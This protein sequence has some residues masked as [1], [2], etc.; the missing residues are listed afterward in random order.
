MRVAIALVLMFASFGSAQA[1][2]L[3]HGRGEVFA[4][5]GSSYLFRA[6]D[7]SFGHP[8]SIGGGVRVPLTRRLGLEVE[9]NRALGLRPEPARCGVL[10]G[11]EGSAREG[12]LDLSLATANLYVRFP[13]GRVEPFL[14]GGA[15]VLWTTT[16]NS[17]TRVRDSIG[18]MSEMEERDAGLAIGFGGGA[19]VA[20]T[21]RWSVRPEIRIYDST[22]MSRSNLAVIR[23][24]LGVGYS[25]QN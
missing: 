13:Y 16:V 4:S 7:R 11:C 8:A 25:W 24:V 18:I 10:A 9:G 20:L 19:T 23:T 6:E 2:S 1:Q 17:V 14:V 3:G 5:L 15:G 21:S 12:V 22:A